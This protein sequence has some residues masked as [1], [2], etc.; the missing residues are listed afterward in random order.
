MTVPEL[1]PAPE[2]DVDPGAAGG[3]VPPLHRELAALVVEAS[4]E[5]ISAADALAQPPEPLGMLGLTSLGFVRLIQAVESRYGVAVE[6]DDDLSELDTVPALADYLSARG[7]AAPDAGTADP[8][9]T[10][11]GSGTP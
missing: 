1:E 5:Q 3:A 8:A 6:M 4:G 11:D 7:V 2:A 10:G 9:P